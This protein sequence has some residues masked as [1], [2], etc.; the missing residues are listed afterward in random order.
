LEYENFPRIH[1]RTLIVCGEF[2][3]T[4]GAAEVVTAALPTG[5]AVVIP[6]FGHMQAF[7]RTDAT[8]PIISD[9]LAR[10][11]PTPSHARF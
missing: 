7:W 11:V 10:H 8:A 4:D 3:N 9:F 6:G 2:E 5:T 1:A